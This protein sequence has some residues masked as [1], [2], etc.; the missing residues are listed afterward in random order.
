LKNLI[1]FDAATDGSIQAALFQKRQSPSR[2]QSAREGCRDLHFFSDEKEIP[3]DPASGM[4]RTCCDLIHMNTLLA[5]AGK[6]C[7]EYLYI[8]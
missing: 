5:V 1:S 4:P 8:L 3:D 6:K 2:H 7:K